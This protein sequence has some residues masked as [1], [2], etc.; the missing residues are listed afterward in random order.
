MIISRK[1]NLRNVAAV[2]SIMRRSQSAA[3]YNMNTLPL[4][5]ISFCLALALAVFHDINVLAADGPTPEQ[6]A[7]ELGNKAKTD[8]GTMDI[9]TSLTTEVG[10]RLAGSDKEKLAA[11]WAKQKFEQLGFDKVSLESFPLEH[12]WV[13]GAEKAEIVGPSPQPLVIAA[14]GGSVGTP[15]EGIEAEIVL[16]HTYEALLAAPVGSLTGKIAVMTQPMGRGAEAFG[17]GQ[18]SKWRT[19]GPGEAS[20]RGAVAYLLRSLGTDSHRIAH[21]GVTDYATNAPPIPAAAMSVPDAEQ[22]D[23]LA[24]M[25]KPIRIRLLLTPHVLGPA[26]SQNVV[27]DLRGREKPDEI[28]LLGA[29]LDSWDQGTGALDDGAGVAIVM[30]AAKL[31]HAL[32]QRPRRTIRVVLFGSEEIGLFGGKAYADAHK[33]ELEHFIVV[34]EPDSGQGPINRFSTGVANPNDPSLVK[35]RAA[36]A[37]LGIE[38]GDNRARGSSD[39]ESLVELKVPAASFGMGGGDYFDFHHTPDDTLDK[40]QPERINQSTAAYAIFAWLA[41]E[42]GADYRAPAPAK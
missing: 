30:G 25:G 31:I 13:R 38:A 23:R 29:H 34:A 19:S 37:P 27:A 9:I 17:Y 1:Y 36:L 35:I 39:V 28:V 4:T 33:N 18:A 11:A 32:P 21:T 10:P 20:R 5:K 42:S 7:A 8:P 12:G 2:K 26:T 40:I 24:A 3:T 16:F 14:L 22:L 6:I 41:A 15:P